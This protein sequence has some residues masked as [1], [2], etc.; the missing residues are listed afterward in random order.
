MDNSEL[1]CR[2][3]VSADGVI[4][5]L[6]AKLSGIP[7]AGKHYDITLMLNGASLSI[8]DLLV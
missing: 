2:K 7:G 6:R 4:K 8:Q 3:V 1:Q 5:N